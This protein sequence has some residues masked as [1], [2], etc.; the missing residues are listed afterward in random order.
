MCLTLLM[1]AYKRTSPASFLPPGVDSHDK[2]SGMMNSSISLREFHFSRGDF[3]LFFVGGGAHRKL[4]CAL[5]CSFLFSSIQVF[6]AFVLVHAGLDLDLSGGRRD[7]KKIY[8]CMRGKKKKN[9]RVPR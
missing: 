1:I 5:I 7:K 4:V 6:V 8:I 9:A 3:D 2:S